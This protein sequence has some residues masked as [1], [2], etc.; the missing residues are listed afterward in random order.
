MHCLLPP[1][2]SIYVDE[3]VAFNEEGIDE[4]AATDDTDANDY[5]ANDD[6]NDATMLPK[7]KPLP[8]KPTK[9]DMAAASVKPPPPAATAAAAAATSFSNFPVGEK[10]IA[11]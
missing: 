1:H 7:V 2:L 6:S 9:K 4:D 11:P 8:M 5:A 3:E 10:L